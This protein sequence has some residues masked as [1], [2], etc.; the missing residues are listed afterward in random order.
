[1][2][3]PKTLIFEGVS[4]MILVQKPLLIPIISS[5]FHIR[6]VADNHVLSTA[7]HLQRFRNRI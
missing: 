1:M 3:E 2:R 7:A 6:I 4:T 5:V